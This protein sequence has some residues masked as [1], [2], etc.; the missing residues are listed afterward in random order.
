MLHVMHKHG[1]IFLETDVLSVLQ[2]SYVYAS[3]SYECSS[4]VPLHNNNQGG[5]V[6]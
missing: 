6:K 4:P 5:S 3:S 1:V 2:T